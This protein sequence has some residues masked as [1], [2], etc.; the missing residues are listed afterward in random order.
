MSQ[1]PLSNILVSDF[2]TEMSVYGS[3]NILTQPQQ[4]QII[5]TSQQ[6]I[7]NLY[8]SQLKNDYQ[9]NTANSSIIIPSGSFIDATQVL[10]NNSHYPEIFNAR[11][12]L[13]KLDAIKVSTSGSV[14]AYSIARYADSTG[15]VLEGSKAIV[16]NS[17]VV[18]S[19]GSVMKRFETFPV[20]IIDGVSVYVDSSG[21]SPNK[22]ITY[23]CMT[24]DSKEIILFTKIV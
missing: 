1:I 22:L 15:V 16:S 7:C 10:Y 11:Q 24:E 12:A 2:I 8:N 17:G 4:L 9:Y 5:N 21:S 6:L 23:K 13:D 20:P 3:F 19:S 14:K 18:E